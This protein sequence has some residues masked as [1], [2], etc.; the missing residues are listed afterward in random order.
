MS[1]S[2]FKL[3]SLRNLMP[4]TVGLY[5]IPRYPP[6]FF[7]FDDQILISSKSNL[8]LTDNSASHYSSV[9]ELRVLVLNSLAISLLNLPKAI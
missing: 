1:M 7:S 4:Y 5:L 8:L 9:N 3:V 6:T 2:S